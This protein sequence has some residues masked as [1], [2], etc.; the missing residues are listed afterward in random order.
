MALCSACQAID[1]SSLPTFTGFR[2]T[3]DSASSMLIG[4]PHRQFQDLRE[5]APSCPLC[6]LL[7]KRLLSA[8]TYPPTALRPYGPDGKPLN[9]V[10]PQD[11]DPVLLR[12]L[13]RSGWNEKEKRF[14]GLHAFCGKL[15]CE[16]GLFAG[17]GQ[18]VSY[19][20]MLL[21]FSN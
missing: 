6:A 18:I 20:S 16:F 11:D 3:E 21:R 17:E 13:S 2:Q 7:L 9:D 14:Y 8:A 4:Q 10:T 1:I 19:W 15:T 12:G 5:S